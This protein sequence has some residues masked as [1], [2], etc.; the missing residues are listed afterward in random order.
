MDLSTSFFGENT[1]KYCTILHDATTIILLYYTMLHFPWMPLLLEFLRST[2]TTRCYTML[3]LP[4]MPLLL[5]F[6]RYTYT[7]RCYNFTKLHWKSII[8]IANETI[9][10]Y[11]CCILVTYLQISIFFSLF[12]RNIKIIQILLS[13]LCENLL[14]V[15]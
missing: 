8:I 11:F 10:I 4:W 9:M 7:A 12:Y 3:H 15:L 1:V 6:L 13:K 5:E 14:Q 2:Y